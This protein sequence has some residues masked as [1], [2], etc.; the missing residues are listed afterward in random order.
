LAYQA[1]DEV[2][3]C[4]SRSCLL[5]SL[6]YLAYALNLGRPTTPADGGRVTALRSDTDHVETREITD[7]LRDGGITADTTAAYHAVW[8]APQR[9]LTA[10][11]AA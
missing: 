6:T 4:I 10:V 8:D 3:T 7:A 2:L 9:D 11:L 5:E 1:A